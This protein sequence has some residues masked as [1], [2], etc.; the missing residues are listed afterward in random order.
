MSYT[1]DDYINPAPYFPPPKTWSYP[2]LKYLDWYL[3]GSHRD[4]H[5]GECGL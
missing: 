5:D 1:E 3:N 2:G 4:G